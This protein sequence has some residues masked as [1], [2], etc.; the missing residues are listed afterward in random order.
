[1]VE[2]VPAPDVGGKN[3][4]VRVSHS[5]IS[6]GTEMSGVR[7]SGQ[8]LYRRALRQ[9]DKVRQALQMARDQGVRRTARFV[10][11]KL[12][13]GSPTGY[14]AAGEVIAVGAE[15]NSFF[16]GVV[17]PVPGRGLPTIRR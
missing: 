5:C 13:A 17:L 3:I 16:L 15:V 14:S 1:M 11:G 9:P 2:D 6:I 7:N 4:L 12:A 8:S 10:L